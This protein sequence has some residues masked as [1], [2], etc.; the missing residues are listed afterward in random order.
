MTPPTGNTAQTRTPATPDFT[1]VARTD[2]AAL[3]TAAARSSG[4]YLPVILIGLTIAAGAYERVIIARWL[5]TGDRIGIIV[6]AAAIT[7]GV[8]YGMAHTYV[9]QARK[10]RRMRLQTAFEDAGWTYGKW[11]AR[12]TRNMHDRVDTGR[13]PIRRIGAGRWQH[14]HTDICVAFASKPRRHAAIININ[15]PTATPATRNE[16]PDRRPG[17][18]EP[19]RHER[20]GHQQNTLLTARHFNTAFLETV[21]AQIHAAVANNRPTVGQSE[22]PDTL[23]ATTTG[24]RPSP[25]GNEP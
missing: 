7:G 2:R 3:L 19:V 22:Q 15:H 25:T 16:E 6:L 11:P 18:A 1:D 24:T 21:A 20:C 10:T 13:R 17:L 8:A 14:D 9:T 12:V 23:D 5:A 4:F